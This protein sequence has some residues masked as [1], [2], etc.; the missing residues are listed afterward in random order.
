M[1]E[2]KD[3]DY[4]GEMLSWNMLVSGVTPETLDNR[5]LYFTNKKGHKVAGDKEAIQAMLNDPNSFPVQVEFIPPAMV[6]G[7]T[8]EQKPAQEMQRV[9]LKFI[10]NAVGN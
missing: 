3:K 1:G 5:I 10:Q 2:L 7:M 4:F 8:P 9:F 6:R